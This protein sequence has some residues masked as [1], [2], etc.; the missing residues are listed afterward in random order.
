[1][2]ASWQGI[3][4]T[5]VPVV[6]I[7]IMTF[8][9][10]GS[11]SQTIDEILPQR[12]PEVTIE[13][14]SFK[15]SQI[16]LDIRNTGLVDVEIAMADVNDRIQPAAVE[17]DGQLGRFESAVVRI[18]FEWNEAEPYSVGVT[19]KDGTRFTRDI[20]AAA[21]VPERGADLVGALVIIG[22]YVGVI[23]VMVGLLWSPFIRN[24]SFS[25]YAFFLSL[26]AGMLFF[27]GIDSLLAALETATENLSDS[28]DGQMLVA[29]IATI[30]FL[31]LYYAERKLA[32]TAKI[33]GPLA[34]GVAISTG[35]GLHNLGEGLAI[36]AAIGLGQAALGAFLIVGFALHNTTEGVAIASSQARAHTSI[37]RLAAL[38]AIAGVPAIFGTLM[39]GLAYSPLAAVIFL[40]IAGGAVFQVILLVLQMLRTQNSN[41]WPKGF[42]LPAG[43]ASGMI[44]MYLTGLIV[45]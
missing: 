16:L 41:K 21:P 15:D 43:I 3:I 13:Q 45:G 7:A 26:T 39:G 11:G 25:R 20:K 14:V 33:S 6:A 5:I 31:G 2:R 35:I 29:T 32:G 23:P 9:L 42:V 12:L 1:M 8:W 37:I 28:F 19:I 17:P 38:G 18:P 27:I 30:S 4:A 22:A 40:S 44:I 10:A 24:A 34:A 36:G